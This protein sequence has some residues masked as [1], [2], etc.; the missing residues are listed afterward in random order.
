M[1]AC[2]TCTKAKQRA[3]A[4]ANP[5]ANRRRA[6]QWAEQNPERVREALKRFRKANPGRYKE[7]ARTRA[8]A[9]RPA[10]NAKSAAHRAR[11]AGAIPPWADMDA[12]RQ[13]Y[14]IA[15][16]L[17]VELGAEFH[18]DHIVPL[19]SKTVQGFHVETNLSIVIS[20]WNQSKSNQIWPDMP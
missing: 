20:H 4:A 19:R 10:E 9:N 7:A 1:S 13:Y 2:K 11:K 16:F 3:Y 15:N 6:R 14:L 5:E 17:S 8:N 12:I 18:V